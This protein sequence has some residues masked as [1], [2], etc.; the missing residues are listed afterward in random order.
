MQSHNI[1][2]ILSTAHFARMPEIGKIE[3]AYIFIENCT[4]IPQ[5]IFL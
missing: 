2:R 5:F 1:L 4:Y 3:S